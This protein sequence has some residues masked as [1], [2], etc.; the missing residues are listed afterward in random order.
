[1]DSANIGAS[2]MIAAVVALSTTIAQYGAGSQYQRGLLIQN[3][4][5][6]ISVFVG[7]DNTLTSSTGYL[8]KAGDSVWIPTSGPVWLIAAS[9]A[10]NVN[11]LVFQN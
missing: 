3:V 8:I 11:I 4:D 9:G 5:A 6:L 2:R 7:G 10:P 1:M